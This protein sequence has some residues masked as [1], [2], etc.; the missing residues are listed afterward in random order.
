MTKEEESEINIWLA[1][2]PKIAANAVLEDEND[3]KHP[4][5]AQ[6]MLAETIQKVMFDA[7]VWLAWQEDGGQ[8]VRA[9]HVQLPRVDALWNAFRVA[10]NPGALRPVAYSQ[11]V[12]E[13][14][15]VHEERAA[16][17]LQLH[18]QV[19]AQRG[20]RDDQGSAQRGCVAGSQEEARAG[21]GSKGA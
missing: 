9:G 1:N 12:L 4:E 19:L 15:P 16:R 7:L 14:H 18:D 21:R 20:T 13:H 10:G 17:L 2:N 8:E 6:T 5:E 3:L 11:N